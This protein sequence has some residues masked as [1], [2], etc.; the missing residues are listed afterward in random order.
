MYICIHVFFCFVYF[1]KFPC[2]FLLHVTYYSYLDFRNARYD[3]LNV[4]LQNI[5]WQQ[6]NETSDINICVNT[7]YSMINSAIS[8]HVE[9][10]TVKIQM[11]FPPWF[12]AYTKLLVIEQKIE[13]C[14]QRL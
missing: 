6:L 9:N 12:D 14:P 10:K 11:N 5:N 3:R 8:M 1:L 13:D 7:F 4:Y 2:A